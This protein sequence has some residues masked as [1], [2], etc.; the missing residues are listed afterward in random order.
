MAPSIFSF[1]EG[2]LRMVP[3]AAL[4]RPQQG[5]PSLPR[6]ALSGTKWCAPAPRDWIASEQVCNVLF[7]PVPVQLFPCTG[8][9]LFGASSILWGGQTQSNLFPS[10]FAENSPALL[11]GFNQNCWITPETL[12]YPSIPTSF[13]KQISH[14]Y[15]LTHWATTMCPVWI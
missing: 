13:F 8:W 9:C 2:S 5:P 11:L 12:L 3:A 14:K 6:A 15:H 10:N 7:V 1:I 4:I